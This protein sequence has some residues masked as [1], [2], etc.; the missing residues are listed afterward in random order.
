MMYEAIRPIYPQRDPLL[1][2]VMEA[3]S[4]HPECSLVPYTGDKSLDKYI[5]ENPDQTG[6]GII[7]EEQRKGLFKREHSINIGYIK[8]GDGLI[9]R[10][11]GK[12]FYF[13]R[14]GN[15]KSR[16]VRGGGWDPQLTELGKNKGVYVALA[17][18][19]ELLEQ[20]VKDVFNNMEGRWQHSFSTQPLSER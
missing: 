13:F 15:D 7:I 20:T 18:I 3:I 19:P 4:Q 10:F 11:K 8:E 6:I 16:E 17:P 5:N 12:E 1:V 9:S 2:D 14:T